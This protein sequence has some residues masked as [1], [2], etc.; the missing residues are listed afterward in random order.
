MNERDA[1]GEDILDVAGADARLLHR[2]GVHGHLHLGGPAAAEVGLEAGRNGDDE[3]ITS[4]IHVAG[5]VAGRNEIGVLELRRIERGHQL[6][7]ELRLVLVDEGEAGVVHLGLDAAGLREDRQREG[8]EDE[9]DEH[10]VARQ[11]A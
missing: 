4:A 5:G 8:V 9:P 6:L 7:G 2:G 10:G 1:I 3:H 11:A